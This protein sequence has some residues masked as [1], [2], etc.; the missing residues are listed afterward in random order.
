MVKRIILL[1]AI[2]GMFAFVTIKSVSVKAVSLKAPA[3][4]QVKEQQLTAPV[5][6]RANQTVVVASGF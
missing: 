5:V 1:L 4:V 3:K 2:L 6:Y